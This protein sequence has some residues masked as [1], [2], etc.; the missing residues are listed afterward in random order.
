M[1][2]K[3]ANKANFSPD[4]EVSL[5]NAFLETMAK[6]HKYITIEALLLSL[7]NNPNIVTILSACSADVEVIRRDITTFLDASNLRFGGTE[8]LESKP[9]EDFDKVIKRAITEVDLV[10]EG[11][12]NVNG[13]D[14]LIALF[15]ESDSQAVKFLHQQGV[16]KQ[17]VINLL[18]HRIKKIDSL[19]KI[20]L[21]TRKELLKDLAGKEKEGVLSFS[22]PAKDAIAFFEQISL[23]NFEYL[24]ALKMGE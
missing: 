23:E 5:H 10:N 9:T 16:T 22:M 12:N 18:G 13:I 8:P 11:K 24:Q 14:V 20:F 6:R 21:L 4:L 19:P 15:D 7:L 3:N 2:A 1:N 17:G